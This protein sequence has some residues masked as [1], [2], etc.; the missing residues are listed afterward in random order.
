MTQHTLE[1]GRPMIADAVDD[2]RPSLAELRHTA[3]HVLAYAVQDL[4]PDAKPTIGPAI[5]NGFYYDFDRAEPFT[6]EDLERLQ[7]RMEEIVGADYPMT[8]REV[9]REEAI[10]AFAGNPYKAEI[11]REIPENDSITLY[12]IGDFTDLCRGGHANSTREIGAFKLTSV[13]GAYWRGDEHKPMLQRIYGTAWRDAEE[14]R[15]YLARVEEAQRRDHR[16]LGA[17][18]DL[19]SIEEDAG[20][21]L[22]FWHPNGAIVRDIIENFIREGLRERGYQPVVTPH[23]VHERLFEISGHLENFSENMFGPIEVENQRFRLKPMNCP[24]HIL[25][26]KSRLRSYRDLPLRFSEFGAV[27]RFERSGALLGLNRVRGFTVDDAHIFCTPEQ[28]QQEFEQTLEEARRVMSAF[29]FSDV[30]YVISTRAPEDRTDTDA[31]AEDAIRKALQRHELPFEVDEGGGAFYGPK[32]DI[33]VRDAIGRPW[34]LGTVQVDF[35]LPARFELRYRGADGQDHR[36]VMIHRALA[37]S[38]ERL[39]GVLIEHYGGAFPAWL[40]P[41]QAVIAP[42]SQEQLSYAREVAAR[43]SGAGFRVEVDESNEKLGYKIRHW[44]TQ[45]VPYILVVGKQEVA[46]GTVNVNERGVDEKRTILVEAFVDELHGTIE[47]KQ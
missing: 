21:G 13:A 23:V 43:L 33:N 25:I 9:T 22:V 37:G 17:E 8:G 3:A 14:L 29:G 11:A 26:Y 36:P 24:G 15:A 18:L 41:I 27:Y 35:I 31:I 45:K 32:L 12:T 6:P 5:E 47:A 28:L 7:A 30:T 2:R 38:L 42:I 46:D 10:A 39:F 19:F 4:F 34:Q 16:K 44:K 40:A 1:A 20:G